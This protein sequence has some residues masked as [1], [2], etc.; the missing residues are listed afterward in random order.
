[1]KDS[2]SSHVGNWR[3]VAAV[4]GALFIVGLGTFNAVAPARDGD[5][6]FYAVG[7]TVAEV[8]PNGARAG[9]Q[10]GD[11]IDYA[12]MPMAD[13]LVAAAPR[14]ASVLRIPVER[15]GRRYVVQVHATPASEGLQG[16]IPD[17]LIE[18]G[19]VILACVV[20]MRARRGELA[21]AVS[22]YTLWSA[23]TAATADV[24]VTATSPMAVF[25]FNGALQTVAS[26]LAYYYAFRLVGL[27][28]EGRSPVQRFALRIAAPISLVQFSYFNSA[29]APVLEPRIAGAA[30]TYIS[31]GA[32]AA[33]G[34]LG[35]SLLLWSTL[36]V[37]PENR[38]RMRWF[39]STLLV[40]AFLGNGLQAI[41]MMFPSLPGGSNV[42]Y[43]I[44]FYLTNFGPIGPIYATLRHR[45]IDLDVVIS[46]SAIY[47]ALSLFVVG[48]FIAGEWLAG[49]VADAFV[50]ESQRGITTQMVSFAIAIAL[51]LSVRTVHGEIEKRIN[52]V[53]FRARTR[54]LQSLE[55]F[56]YEA[57]ITESREGLLNLTYETLEQSIDAPV[58]ALYLWQG[59]RFELF[60]SGASSTPAL[61]D[62]NERLVLRLLRWPQ[63]FQFEDA[64]TFHDWLIVPLM[65]RTNVIG[66]MACGPK[67]DHTRYV[68]DEINALNTLAHHVA[69]SYAFISSENTF[70]I[71]TLRIAPA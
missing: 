25:I 46:R 27:F 37:A 44:L 12:A 34:L 18:L 11:R 53:F 15:S 61:L 19:C 52:G 6:G 36:H 50:A 47:A 49:R 58:V 22:G 5:L 17:L 14:A 64:G 65:V 3:I 31:Y 8:S 23:A 33:A 60:R 9:L 24:A 13:R 10:V 21:A 1:M 59:A 62:K 56:A 20:L 16:R 32:E 45:L 38:A 26:T 2:A 39:A 70:R 4:A 71:E 67:E 48:L 40:F 51:G 54:R 66:F 55:R 63:T 69:T 29:F 35:F 68:S 57:D 43:N 28:P 42:A 7:N 41:Y 30:L